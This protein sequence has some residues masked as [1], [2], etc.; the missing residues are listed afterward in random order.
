MSD[1]FTSEYLH[2]VNTDPKLTQTT[3]M[4]PPIHADRRIP[5]RDSRLAAMSLKPG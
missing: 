5:R 3:D 1:N 2:T 4:H